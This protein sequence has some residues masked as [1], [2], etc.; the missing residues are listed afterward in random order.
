M[1][2]PKLN[3][4]ISIAEC[5]SFNKASEQ[6]YM[7]PPS[8]MKQMDGLEAHLQIKLIERTSRGIKLTKAGESL[9]QDTKRLRAMADAAIATARTIAEE[10]K[11]VYTIRIGT[12]PLY[13]IGILI[14]LW[15]KA[16]DEKPEEASKFHFKI[17]STRDSLNDL[18]P[19]LGKTVDMVLRPCDSHEMHARCFVK[20]I[21]YCRV[22]VSVSRSS[23][24]ASKTIL[25]MNDF[26]GQ[27]VVLYRRS[28]TVVMDQI[29]TALEACPGIQISEV[30][31]YNLEQFNQYA[32][33]NTILIANSLWNNFHPSMIT[34]PVDWPYL[35]PYGI[36]CAPEH[37]PQVDA[38]IGLI[39]SVNDSSTV[40]PLARSDIILFQ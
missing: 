6:L 27:H 8:V 15:T 34:V 16:C 2:D 11:D 14:N 13:P 24:M 18:L 25:T 31:F 26:A 21:G 19:S 33:S 9:Y 20:P 4:F 12:S 38:F 28:D 40:Y 3:T 23:P 10:E 35:L 5:G 32:N 37:S 39:D 7:T 1:L 22:F 30:G 17:V 29:A 36:I